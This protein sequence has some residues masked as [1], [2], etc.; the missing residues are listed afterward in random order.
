MY[1]NKDRARSGVRVAASISLTIVLL[2]SLVA[3]SSHGGAEAS[4][5]TKKV[6]VATILPYVS[7]KTQYNIYNPY[8]DSSSDR[9]QIN[10]EDGLTSARLDLVNSLPPEQKGAASNSVKALISFA[11][12]AKALGFTYLSYGLEKGHSPD[13]DLA[14]PVASVKAAAAAAH[15][16]GLLLNVATSKALTIQWGPKLAK[17]ADMYHMQSQSLQDEPSKYLDFVKT[18][19]GKLRSA[20]PNLKQITVQL[21]TQKDPAPGLTLQETFK[22]DWKNVRPYVDGVRIW[23]GN[24]STDDLENFVKWFDTYG[25]WYTTS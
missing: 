8:T 23:F 12:K 4:T 5:T 6:L 11:P 20:N 9:V 16:N 17:Y 13:S 19:A 14:D 10:I 21:S 3:I 25:R 18:M 7:L 1:Y 2:L 15:S 24:D 22:K